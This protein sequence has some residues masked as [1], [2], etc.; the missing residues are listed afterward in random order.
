MH[1]RA[2]VKPQA[3]AYGKPQATA[4]AKPQATAYGTAARCR[5]NDSRQPVPSR[6]LRQR[7]I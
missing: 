4:Y 3:T 6:N 7:P 2:F 1:D 5:C